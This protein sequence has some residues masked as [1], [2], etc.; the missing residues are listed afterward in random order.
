MK[1]IIGLGNPGAKYVKTRHN[2]GC[3]FL[4]Y[5]GQKLG[6]KDWEEKSKFKAVVAEC[7]ADRLLLVKPTTF[8]NLSGE[9]LV[10]IKQFYN[11]ANAD[12]LVVYDDV[13]LPFGS[14]RFKEKGSAGT[15]NGMKSV[16]EQLGTDEISRLRIGIE[17]RTDELKQKW[18]LNEYVLANFVEEELAQLGDIFL[19]A[20][21][22]TQD[23]IGK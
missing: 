10:A 11:L 7:G 2:V 13:D 16:V 5:L 18:A 12:I 9:A 17:N 3:L 14:I 4:D 20:E 6:C 23:F 22:K 1:L 15:H 19:E 21:Q 8:M